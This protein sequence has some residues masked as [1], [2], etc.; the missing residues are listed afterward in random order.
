MAS[1]RRLLTTS[2]DFDDGVTIHAQDMVTILMNET[3]PNLDHT[4]YFFQDF[5]SSETLDPAKSLIVTSVYNRNDLADFSSAVQRVH[6]IRSRCYAQM[7]DE[8]T[9]RYFNLINFQTP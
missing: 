3:V 8:R 2:T 1:P 7:S 9:L 5:T 4:L 6:F